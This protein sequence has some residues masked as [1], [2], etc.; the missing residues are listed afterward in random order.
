MQFQLF[1]VPIT[2]DGSALEELNRFLR[3]HKIL[4]VE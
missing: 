3:G 2:D 1:T 4:E